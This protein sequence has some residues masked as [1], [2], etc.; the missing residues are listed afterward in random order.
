MAHYGHNIYL[1]IMMVEV[2]HNEDDP[3]PPG[4]T[5]Q[6]VLVRTQLLSSPATS[7][8]PTHSTFPLLPN[9]SPSPLSCLLLFTP[10]SP[11]H[12]DCLSAD[13]SGSLKRSD[14][15]RRCPFSRLQM[16]TQLRTAATFSHL[17]QLWR[18]DM[19]VPH[20]II[21]CITCFGGPS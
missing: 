13:L 12:S 16:Y 1:E 6:V 18:L 4:S 5:G 3:Y 7:S 14:C 10:Y 19:C 8:S 9:T 20:H 17:A 15:R 21:S 2:L 11:F